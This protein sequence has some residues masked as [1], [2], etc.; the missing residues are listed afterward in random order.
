MAHNNEAP[1]TPISQLFLRLFNSGSE[2]IINCAMSFR[3]PINVEALK[4][5]ITNSIM[6]KHPRF[7]SLM[8]R[9][10][11]GGEHWKKTHV[12]IDDHFII[13]DQSTNLKS[14]DDDDDD[15]DEYERAINSYL[16]EISVSTLRRKNKPL[17]EVHVLLGFKCVVLRVDHKLGDGVSLMSMLSACFGKKSD[18]KSD[19]VVVND[20]DYSM[21]NHNNTK[22]KDNKGISRDES[23]K[24]RGVW[25]LVKSLWFTKVF[26]FRILGRLS[27]VKDRVS[28]VSG[29]DGVELWPRKLVTAKFLLEDFKP[30]K[31]IIPQVTINDVL[32]G[33]IS[34]GLSKYLTL[35]S[36]QAVQQTYQLTAMCAVNLRKHPYLQEMSDLMSIY[37]NRLSGWGNKSSFILL[38]LRCCNELHPLDH[39]RAM[40]AIMDRKKQSYEALVLYKM[41]VFS[42]KVMSWCSRRLLANTTLIISNI[43]GPLEEIVIA[44]NPVTHMKVNVSGLRQAITLHIVSYQGKVNLQVMVAKDIIP[45]PEILV[46]CFQDS[47]LEIKNSI[48]KTSNLV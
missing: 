44:D 47:F 12:C 17:W 31:L 37:S 40:K 7:C 2:Q 34:S 48:N 9:N 23:K 8:V 10:P 41:A 30:I 35:K 6:I 25:G 15:E 5:D 38:P 45:D 11:S 46:K 21:N 43:K 26:V 22:P 24:K 13:H 36:S 33:V 19:N 39:V 29:G 1:N 4:N 27:W 28:V 20:G 16:A 18:I 14:N 32:L 3:D 42:T